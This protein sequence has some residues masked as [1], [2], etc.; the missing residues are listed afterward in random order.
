MTIHSKL[1]QKYVL[2]NLCF[3]LLPIALFLA[4]YIHTTDQQVSKDLRASN[5]YALRQTMRTVD[6]SADTLDTFAYRLGTSNQISPY[7]LQRGNYSTIEALNQLEMYTSQFGFLENLYLSI[8]GDCTLY[9]GRGTTSF[10]TLFGRQ[11]STA[12]Q[13]YRLEGAWTPE[14]LWSLFQEGGNF[15]IAGGELPVAQC[16][17]RTL[18]FADQSLEIHFFCADRQ[19]YRRCQPKILSGT[20]E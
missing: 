17:W 15:H 20:F 4:L 16:A 9:S 7:F 13:V 12:P 1:Y 10:G 5:E 14:D 19:C 6:A 18:L 2:I 3:I 11:D 8:D